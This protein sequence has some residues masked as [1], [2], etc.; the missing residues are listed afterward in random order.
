[1]NCTELFLKD[2]SHKVIA[3][4]VLLAM[5][6]L[7]AWAFGMVPVT[8]EHGFVLRAELPLLIQAQQGHDIDELKKQAAETSTK[9]DNIKTALDQILADYYS[10]RVQDGVRRRCKLSPLETEERARLWD[11][12][13]RDVNLYRIYSGDSNYERPSCSEV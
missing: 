13:T 8:G 11:Q 12:I 2:V 9:V 3:M 1:M 4:I 6:G 7:W 5:I 10:K